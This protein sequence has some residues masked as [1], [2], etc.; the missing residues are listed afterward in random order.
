[1]AH[2]ETPLE[3]HGASVVI[4]PAFTPSSRALHRDETIV[5]MGQNVTLPVALPI[6]TV[7]LLSLANPD[8]ARHINQPGTQLMVTS[9]GVSERQPAPRPTISHL[10]R[11]QWLQGDRANL[12]NSGL[13]LYLD[14]TQE[15]EKDPAFST[16]QRLFAEDIPSTREMSPRVPSAPHSASDN[17]PRPSPSRQFMEHVTQT[18]M[19]KPPVQ[20]PTTRPVIN[21][22]DLAQS[23]TEVATPSQA[24]TPVLNGSDEVMQSIKVGI[25]GLQQDL[26]RA[27]QTLNE[28]RSA[29]PAF[30]KELNGAFGTS[31]KPTSTA[32]GH[33][34][35]N[36]AHEQ[37]ITLA[38]LVSQI[39]SLRNI[40]AT[41]PTL[42]SSLLSI[43]NRLDALESTSFSHVSVE[44][45][46]DRVELFDGRLLD[47]ESKVDDLERCNHLHEQDKDDRR[48][49]QDLPLGS[50][51]SHMSECQD[52]HLVRV[53]TMMRLK[54]LEDRLINLEKACGPSM[55]QPWE[56]EI[57]LFP[58]GHDLK[59]IW[60]P[61]DE[62]SAGSNVVTQDSNKVV[63]TNHH[64]ARSPGKH[65]T[66]STKLK[67][68]NRKTIQEWKPSSKN[69]RS[70]RACGPTKG[71]KGRLFDRL[72]SRGFVR[73]VSF[74]HDHSDH[75]LSIVCSAFQDLLK[76]PARQ[77][78]VDLE[79]S[80]M[81]DDGDNVAPFEQ[82]MALHCPFIPLRKVHKSTRL[83]FLSP[84]ELSTPS[85]WTANFL[86][87][88]V[89]MK[90][91][92]QGLTRLYVTTPA[93]YLQN[94]EAS[95]WTWQKIREL[96]RYE[97][98][99]DDE[100]M[101]DA[102]IQGVGEADAC[103]ACWVWDARLDPPTSANSSF[104]SH[105]S[106]G[107]SHPLSPE[108]TEPAF[109]SESEH[110][111]SEADDDDDDEE[112]EQN[113]PSS[114]SNAVARAPI[115]PMSEYPPNRVVT[116]ARRTASFPVGELAASQPQ[117]NRRSQAPQPKREVASFDNLLS[118][119]GLQ[120][121]S[122]SPPRATAPPK[123]RRMSSRV[124]DADGSLRAPWNWTPRRSREP[125]SPSLAVGPASAGVHATA[126]APSRKKMAAAAGAYATPHSNHVAGHTTP[127]GVGAGTQKVGQREVY[128]DVDM[129]EA[130]DQSGD[131]DEEN[132]QQEEN[133]QP[134]HQ[135]RSSGFRRLSREEEME[136]D[137]VITAE[138][139]GWDGVAGGSES[140]SD[141]D[142]DND[143]ER[144]R[145]E[146][147]DYRDEDDQSEESDDDHD[148]ERPDEFDDDDL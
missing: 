12:A 67:R 16:L 79:D 120:H 8:R 123:R 2:L 142:D 43:S 73:K 131:S 103:E 87:A 91:P 1:M 26:V 104:A 68:S 111:R 92:S 101:P 23:A 42:G 77:G 121:S 139:E 84:A 129:S 36:S 86:D 102:D 137:R 27:N 75:V 88:N 55:S 109:D 95:A 147:M 141:S 99:H 70:A 66:R 116:S 65:S 39:A 37:N 145:D 61:E 71:S 49:A 28:R 107:S 115:T 34:T 74:Y 134:R 127:E 32:Q 41:S 110:E 6:S 59:G 10:S 112:A 38:E 106:F 135:S 140:E 97:G 53:D 80:A 47:I 136:F 29:T 56:V 98:A 133:E 25:E 125:R 22:D 138:E 69:V 40:L 13:G 93:A 35:I 30:S 81:S 108:V 113:Q 100:D 85:L 7:L 132:E 19:N 4:M 114:S 33:A 15:T 57:V 62:A 21:I 122:P 94:A 31:V 44:D 18:R 82:L 46:G 17:G 144:N 119:T 117:A 20:I 143:E 83:Q 90:A 5:M 14:R 60:F 96:P 58:W 24:G 89:F 50:F 9:R 124:S 126:G 63:S 3:E 72:R 78:V 118:G 45:I 64:S 146:D 54:Y 105:G 148:N 130:S 48:P 51:T 128:S 11:D 76:A 52:G